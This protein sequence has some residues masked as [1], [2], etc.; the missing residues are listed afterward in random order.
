MK[1][2]TVRRPRVP[3]GAARAAP[4]PEDVA[5][6]S[7]PTEDGEGARLLRWKRGELY[8]GEVRPAKQGEP[9]GEQEL[10]RLRPL[11]DRVPLCE[12]ETVYAPAGHAERE[13]PARI[14]TDT[15]RRNWDVVFGSGADRTPA[16]RKKRPSEL[17]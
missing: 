8:A 5:L 15:Y 6:L 1:K 9:L 4:P 13:G 12:V 11:H 3:A 2:R 14:A 10:V 16:A 7:G 17:N